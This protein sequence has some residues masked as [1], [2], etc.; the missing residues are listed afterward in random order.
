MHT[1]RWELAAE[2]IVV[3][4]RWF[5]LF[6]GYLYVN[7]GPRDHHPLLLNAI[8]AL[9]AAYTAVDTLSSLKGRVF[10]GRF[11]LAVSGM[12]SL[13]IGLL[14]Y[15]Q[16]G[17][18]NAFRFYY[19]LSLICCAIR[20]SVAVTHATC[21]LHCLSVAVVYTA[22]PADRREPFEF[23]LTLLLLAWVAWG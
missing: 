12:E 17:L 20:H 4:I 9:G 10:L 22:L 19:L 2:A 6:L 16:G 1:P 21:A 13:F 7:T 23:V 14:C 11:P 3:K 5:G 15:Y 18:E 8:L